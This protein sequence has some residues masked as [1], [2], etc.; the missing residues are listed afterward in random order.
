MFFPATVGGNRMLN[1]LVVDC[2]D[3]DLRLDGARLAG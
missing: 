2:G 3:A 1:V